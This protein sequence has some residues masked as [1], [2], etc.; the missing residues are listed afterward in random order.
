MK[1]YQNHSREEAEKVIA[2]S[3]VCFVGFA[4]TDGTPYVL[5]MNF[6]YHDGIIYLHSAP[7]GSLIDIVNRNNRVCI[8]FSVGEKLVHQHPEVA[9]SYRMRSDSAICR[10][11]V[12]FVE[13]V[14]AKTDI[15]NLTMKHYAGREFTY[16]SP[17]INNVKIWKIVVDSFSSKS[18]G[19]T[20]K[21][22]LA[23]KENHLNNE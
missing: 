13:D 5:P 22:Y 20:H 7:D 11:K 14:A 17:A 2:D 15:M 19:L 10:G 3:K 21:E 16:S 1:S 8:T 4:D 18:L 23:K 6:A 12:E 9:C